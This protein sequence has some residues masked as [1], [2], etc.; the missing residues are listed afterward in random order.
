[1]VALPA[2]QA[3]ASIGYVLSTG[4][5]RIAGQPCDDACHDAEQLAAF[6]AQVER[7][8]AVLETAARG[9]SP[10][11]FERI[12]GFQVSIDDG[13]GVTTGS[14]ADGRI[15][16]GSGL[17]RLEPADDVTAFLLA[18]EMAHVIARHD[19]ENSGARMFTSGITTL[20]PGVNV[21]AKLL[22]SVLGSG[23][24]V[25]SWGEK[26][27]READE[28]AIALLERTG[29]SADDVARNLASGLKK[30]RLPEG[31]WAERYAESAGRVALLAALPPRY[32]DFGD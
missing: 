28:I 19:E 12:D 31:D 9:L 30:D 16:L 17:S 13:L 7:L 25:F 23:A 4:A 20:I 29:R 14:S 22:A 5:K 15:A 26:Q 10:G 24:V 11:L 27:R 21:I 32:A 2:V 6:T 3:H 18:R 1:M 8:R